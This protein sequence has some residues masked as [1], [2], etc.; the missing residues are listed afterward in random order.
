[1]E[2]FLFLLG[3][4]LAP[5]NNMAVIND[6]RLFSFIYAYNSHGSYLTSSIFPS[7]THLTLTTLQISKDGLLI[8]LAL[9][10]GRRR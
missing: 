2:F 3:V 10:V 8:L 9:A 7:D 1:M 6:M 5:L 4:M